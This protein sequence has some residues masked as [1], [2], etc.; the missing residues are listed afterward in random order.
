[1]DAFLGVSISPA[2]L[3]GAF[4][5]QRPVLIL[6]KMKFWLALRVPGAA[7]MYVKK[8]MRTGTTTETGCGCSGIA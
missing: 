3:A 7:C 2:N 5:M 6:P 8:I 1:V 4:S